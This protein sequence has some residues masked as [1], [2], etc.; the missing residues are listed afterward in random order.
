M[1][2]IA[3][4]LKGYEYLNVLMLVFTRG[5]NEITDEGVMEVVSVVKGFS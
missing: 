3:E 5:E 4:M 2:M 1:K